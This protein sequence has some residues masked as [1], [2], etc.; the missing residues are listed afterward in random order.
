[1]I[2]TGPKPFKCT[3]HCPR[4]PKYL[5][6]KWLENEIIMMHYDKINLLGFILNTIHTLVHKST[7]YAAV[8]PLTLPIAPSVTKESRGYLSRG[9]FG[10]GMPL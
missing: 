9:S 6:T 8:I 4:K 5:Y 10:I 1:M 2:I 7:I 3:E